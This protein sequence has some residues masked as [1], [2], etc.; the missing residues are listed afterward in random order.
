MSIRG[1]LLMLWEN[2]ITEDFNKKIRRKSV[3]TFK[4]LG[5]IECLIKYTIGCHSVL[6]ICIFSTK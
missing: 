3:I 1:V 6:F 4:Q 5:S 2:V